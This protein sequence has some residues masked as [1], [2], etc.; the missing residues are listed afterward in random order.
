MAQKGSKDIIKVL[1]VMKT[2]ECFVCAK[3]IIY[4]IL[5]SNVCSCKNIYSYANTT[6]MRHWCSCEG[7]TEINIAVYY[8]ILQKSCI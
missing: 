4:K 2:H 6:L 7:M 5:I 1:H 8:N 3:N